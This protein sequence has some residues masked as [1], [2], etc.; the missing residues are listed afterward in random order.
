MWFNDEH[1]SEIIYTYLNNT[2]TVNLKNKYYN[3]ITKQVLIIIN[4]VF[5][6]IL[7]LPLLAVCRITK[8]LTT[9]IDR[10]S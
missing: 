8:H 5:I 6:I 7:A 1:A 2:Q 3:M 10:K 9:T 4:Y